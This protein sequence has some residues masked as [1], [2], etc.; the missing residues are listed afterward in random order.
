M[1]QLLYSVVP[2]AWDDVPLTLETA[3]PTFG[4]GIPTLPLWSLSPYRPIQQM[5]KDLPQ[6]QVRMELSRALNQQRQTFGMEESVE[7]DEDDDTSLRMSGDCPPP[8]MEHR[9]LTVSSKGNMSATFR[10]PGV[11]T[12]PSDNAAHSFTIV[13]L[14]LDASMTW[15]T[16]P[17]IDAKTHLKVRR[18]YFLRRDDNSHCFR[19]TG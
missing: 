10:V 12:I 6:K 4:V 13:Q 5:K 2:Q 11:I 7:E 16:I 17:K 3:M 19:A 1:P 15:V 18:A 8:E 14:K 9:R